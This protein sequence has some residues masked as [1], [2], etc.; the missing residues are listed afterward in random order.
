MFVCVLGQAHRADILKNRSTQRASEMLDLVHKYV[1]STID[2]VHFS[3][4]Q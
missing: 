4:A 3:G 1:R 2:T